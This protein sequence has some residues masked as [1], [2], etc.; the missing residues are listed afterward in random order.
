MRPD[1]YGIEQVVEADRTYAGSRF[2]EVRD[3]IFA[4]PYP[5]IIDADGRMPVYQVTLLSLLHGALS[6][7]QHYLFRQAVA[8]AIDSDADLRCPRVREATNLNIVVIITPK[9]PDL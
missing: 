3:A 4:N 9:S 7:G 6:F 5:G 1:E 2:A 8:R